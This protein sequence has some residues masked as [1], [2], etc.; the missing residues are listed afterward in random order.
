M[1]LNLEDVGSD[2]LEAPHDHNLTR[3]DPAHSLRHQDTPQNPDKRHHE[4]QDP[5]PMVP[6]GKQ[7]SLVNCKHSDDAHNEAANS[8][9]EN[10]DRVVNM[11]CLSGDDDDPGGE[12]GHSHGG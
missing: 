3:C 11:F 9:P 5:H 4:A 7:R 10:E 12:E 6:V 1:F 2:N 8:K